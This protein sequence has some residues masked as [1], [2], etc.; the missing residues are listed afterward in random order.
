MTR[1]ERSNLIDKLKQLRFFNQRA[2]RELWS[3]KSHEIQDK[4]IKN[5]D[6]ILD[7]AISALSELGTKANEAIKPY[8][9]LAHSVSAENKGEWIPVSERLPEEEQEVLCQL[10]DGSC[11][12][13]YVQDNWGQ[14]DWVDGQM[15]TGSY[16]VIAWQ[17]LPEPYK[18]E[19]GE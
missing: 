15:G 13:L 12:V 18:A 2:G 9:E 17:P 16:D 4:D 10:S 14:M 8:V 1:E 6:E 3:D 11:A 7:M 19:R 5:A